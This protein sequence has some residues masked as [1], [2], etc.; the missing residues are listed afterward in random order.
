VPWPAG[1]GALQRGDLLIGTSPRQL[2]PT[3]RRSAPA[4][5][6]ARE[7]TVSFEDGSELDVETVIWATGFRSDYL[8]IHAPVLDA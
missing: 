6:G 7:R 5:P 1:A 4:H 8:W 3:W 2:Q